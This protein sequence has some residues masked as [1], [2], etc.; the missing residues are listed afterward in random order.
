MTTGWR[1]SLGQSLQVALILAAVFMAWG[2]LKTHLALVEYRL[3]L[4][5]VRADQVDKTVSEATKESR[6]HR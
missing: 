3:T 4:L 2:D 5:E 1:I 6:R